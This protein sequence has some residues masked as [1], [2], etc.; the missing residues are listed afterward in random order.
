MSR[1]W[2]TVL[3]LG[4]CC[5]GGSN[6]GR[7]HEQLNV[8]LGEHLGVKQSS[9]CNGPFWVLLFTHFK[10]LILWGNFGLF[11]RLFR[12]HQGDLLS[13][14]EVKGCVHLNGILSRHLDV[15]TA[16]PLELFSDC[17]V[18]FCQ[19][20][21]FLILFANVVIF[22]SYFANVV[23]FLSYF[24]NVV[25]LLFCQCCYVVTW[26]RPCTSN[27]RRAKQNM[28]FSTIS[29]FNNPSIFQHLKKSFYFLPF[30]NLK[31]CYLQRLQGSDL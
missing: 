17:F 20:C 15:T 9:F 25:I 23:I 21:H 3:D 26:K 2:Q 27:S 4:R 30:L 6:A 8:L 28:P 14:G 22:L 19:V 29:P 12:Y 5:R 10:T 13:K 18:S 11:P 31:T 16:T 24:A 7:S 1:K